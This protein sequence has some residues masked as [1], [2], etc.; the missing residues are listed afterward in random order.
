[1]IEP[2]VG[3]PA[4]Q[5]AVP[6]AHGMDPVKVLALAERLSEEDAAPLP[7]LLVLGC[8]PLVRMNG[9]EPDVEVGLS[10]PVREAVGE[11]VTLLETLIGT[12]LQD[13]QANLEE[14]A[15]KSAAG[16]RS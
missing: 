11:A 9:D 10:T 14:P 12:L 5:Q 16:T 15:M 7:R 2:E 8:E 1:V 3:E 13:P 4:P 6:E